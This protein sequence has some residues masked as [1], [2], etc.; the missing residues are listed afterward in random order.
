MSWTG[1]RDAIYT[2]F[3]AQS[4]VPTSRVNLAMFNGSVFNPPSID[5]DTPSN[6][7]W[8]RPQVDA[9]PGATPI[10]IGQ[11]AAMQRRGILTVAHFF[12]AGSG[13][14]DIS[15]V[16]D[17]ITAFHRIE[18]S[19]TGLVAEFED[20]DE[21]DAV[22][23]TDDEAWFQINA[24]IPF[25]VQESSTESLT[26]NQYI[27]VSQSSHGFAVG[28]CIG[29]NDSTTQWQ[30]I[31]ATTAGAANISLVG[32]CYFV[33]NANRFMAALPGSTVLMTGHGFGTGALYLDQSTAGSVTTTAPTSGVKWKVGSALDAN[34]VAV[35]QTEPESL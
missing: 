10:G 29:F 11:S 1:A 19:G 35:L 20:A 27:S 13:E 23:F 28:D 6:S 26:L 18:V 4:P 31:V 32:F 24:T 33:P 22:G 5:F 3:L 21:P 15:I 2:R 7:T 30:K 34:R 25:R 16:N 8:V 12:V 9:V 17:T 14:T